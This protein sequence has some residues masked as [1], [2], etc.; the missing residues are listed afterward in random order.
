MQ[1]LKA[2]LAVIS[3]KPN[4]IEKQLNSVLQL[5]L[6]NEYIQNRIDYFKQFGWD[7][8]VIWEHELKDERA[9]INRLLEFHGLSSQL[10]SKQLFFD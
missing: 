8:L 1:W 3:V 10:C 7:T 9:V 2:R 6:P 5:I 4:K